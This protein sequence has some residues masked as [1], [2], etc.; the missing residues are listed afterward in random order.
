MIFIE[1]EIF[2]ST[3]NSSD[4]KLSSSFYPLEIRLLIIYNVQLYQSHSTVVVVVNAHILF[5]LLH[6][7][8]VYLSIIVFFPHLRLCIY[9]FIRLSDTHEIIN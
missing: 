9:S 6:F 4:G 3:E 7:M 8:S 5:Y 1:L 2:K